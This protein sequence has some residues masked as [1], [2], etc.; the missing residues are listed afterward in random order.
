MATSVEMP[1]Q[2]TMRALAGTPPT[3]KERIAILSWAAGRWN[4]LAGKQREAERLLRQALEAAP[5]LRP[6]MRLMS[7]LHRARRDVRSLVEFIDAEIRNTRH[8]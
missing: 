2:E 7:T 5:D 8:P 1:L 4:L 3:E 6:A